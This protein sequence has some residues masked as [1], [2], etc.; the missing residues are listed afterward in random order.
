MNA[1]ADAP[2]TVQRILNAENI[3]ST[4]TTSSQAEFDRTLSVWLGESD[5]LN[6]YDIHTTR[7]IFRQGDSMKEAF[8]SAIRSSPCSQKMVYLFLRSDT[9]LLSPIDIPTSG[10]DSK[11]I[12]IPTWE[13]WIGVTYNDRFALAGVQAAEIYAAAKSFAF[14]EM[15]LDQMSKKEA[16]KKLGTPERM[17]KVWLD[18]HDLNITLIHDWAKLMRVRSGGHLNGRDALQFHISQRNV[19]DLAFAWTALE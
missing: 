6:D 4:V 9:L 13:S 17:L 11:D 16:L 18:K 10:L 7:N 1:T 14:K 5:T 2:D 15:V 19:D 12:H 8:L 3:S